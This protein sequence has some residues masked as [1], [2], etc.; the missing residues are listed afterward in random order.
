MA[1]HH[2]DAGLGGAAGFGVGTVI[3]TTAD[4]DGRRKDTAFTPRASV[5]FKPNADH[6][7]VLIRREEPG[8]RRV[9]VLSA[10]LGAAWRSPLSDVM[11]VV[12]R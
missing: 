4:F 8:T 2:H 3:A 1:S 11:L 7:Y 12:V 10:D 9:Q 6:S 5:S